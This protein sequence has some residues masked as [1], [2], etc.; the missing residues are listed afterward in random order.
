MTP[1]NVTPDHL[2][3]CLDAY[4]G[5]YSE[6]YNLFLDMSD[7][8]LY[9]IYKADGVSISLY[10]LIGDGVNPLDLEFKMRG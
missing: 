5:A 1:P 2:M 6:K 8:N 7:P 10:K 4:C 9:A 3:E